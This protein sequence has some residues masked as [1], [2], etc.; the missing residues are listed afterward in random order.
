LHG[1]VVLEAFGH[2]SFVGEHQAEIFH[3]VMR[4]LFEDIHRRIPAQ[5]TETPAAP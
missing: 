1:L 2:T 4:D 5:P 3:M